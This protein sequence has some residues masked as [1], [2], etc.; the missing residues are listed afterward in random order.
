MFS[1][2]G[3]NIQS[4]KRGLL[5]E[6]V[7]SLQKEQLKLHVKTYNTL[8][9]NIDLREIEKIANM[10]WIN[11]SKVDG[12]IQIILVD[13]DY[14]RNLNKKYLHKDSATDVIAFPLSGDNEKLI[15]GEIYI[16]VE[17]VK[18]QA[19]RYKVKLKEELHRMVIHG[20]LHL[21]GYSDKTE[22]DKQKMTHL[23]NY[24]LA[25]SRT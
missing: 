22:E 3:S 7:R 20:I 24:F 14:I 13:D 5:T 1:T 15:E 17:T 8:S 21:L 25:N 23:E 18:E 11:Q 16:S 2:V 19:K 12:H 10:V 6:G 9:E 4:K